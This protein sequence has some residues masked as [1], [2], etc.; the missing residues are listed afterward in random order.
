ME[1]HAELINNLAN[2]IKELGF[3][4]TKQRSHDFNRVPDLIVLVGNKKVAI[5]IINS[6][7][8]LT[9]ISQLR[10]IRADYYII[11]APRTAIQNTSRSVI[12][13]S[14]QGRV[15]I[16]DYQDVTNVIRSIEGHNTDNLYLRFL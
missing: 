8:T 2:Q 4:V 5:E 16:C 3:R 14:K 15:F 6:P 7:I 1:S 11:C 10:S 9:K 13:Y 12:E